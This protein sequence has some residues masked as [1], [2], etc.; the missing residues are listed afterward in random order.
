MTRNYK[1]LF[2]LLLFSVLFVGCEVR[3][4]P[5]LEDEDIDREKITDVYV[6]GNSF[7]TQGKKTAILWKNGMLLDYFKESENIHGT[8]IF[9]N[10]ENIYISGMKYIGPIS[11]HYTIATYWLNGIAYELTDGSV[12]AT[13][14]AIF[15]DGDDIYVA[16][17]VDRMP[18]YWKNDEMYELPVGPGA[19]GDAADIF[20]NDGKVY[21]AGM[22]SI[23]D[24]EISVYWENGE[25][26]HL[27]S[28]AY[29]S[30]ASGIYVDNGN[31]HVCGMKS[32]LNHDIAAYWMNGEYTELSADTSYVKAYGIYVSEGNVY[33]V[34]DEI[35]LKFD[36]S[37]PKFGPSYAMLWT[38]GQAEFITKN[39]STTSDIT[40]FDGDV[41]ISGRES[42]NKVYW[43]N[44]EIFYLEK[45]EGSTVTTEAI[46]VSYAW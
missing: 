46:Y 25:I 10:N 40:V 37:V 2:S 34:G 23:R 11:D 28:D 15:V 35:N 4:Y 30:Y 31:V 42:F 18:V 43:K 17:N 45:P 33:I 38:N 7:K 16:G 14:N 26:H 36:G 39:T 9:I 27:Y 24:Q 32:N 22:E 5:D 1:A 6:L 8:D 44:G 12:S 20:V 41:Y 3:Y 21:I 19:I 29:F 13:A